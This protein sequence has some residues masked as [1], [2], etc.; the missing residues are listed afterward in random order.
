MTIS[1]EERLAGV[2]RTLN[3]SPNLR[4]AIHRAAE[5]NTLADLVGPNLRAELAR[6][7]A[8]E[9]IANGNALES[10]LPPLALEAIVKRIGRP[11]LLVANRE[12][13]LVPLD[14]FPAT[15]PAL[16]KGTEPLVQ[17][18]GRVAFVNASM[19][20]GGTGWVVKADGSKRVVATN[21]HVAKIV[22]SR[23]ADGSAF[24]MRSPAGPRYGA[25]VDFGETLVPQPGSPEPF[26]VT[27][28]IYLADDLSPDVALLEIEG[29]GLP[30]AFELADEEA[31]A[32]ELVALIGYPAFD[33]RNDVAAQEFYFHD[34]YD[35]KRYAPG[36]V[37]QPLGTE[38]IFTHDCTSLGG[39]SG[40]PLLRLRDGK[41]VGLHFAGKFGVANSAVGVT[42]LRRVLD[43]NPP[44]T[45]FSSPATTTEATSDGTHE[46]D[47]FAGRQ[48]YD[49]AFLGGGQHL[50]PWPGLPDA[51]TAVLA[52]PTDGTAANPHELR[53]THFG[54][55]Y[56]SDRRQ[57]LMTAVNIDGAKSVRIKRSRDRWFFDKRVPLEIQLNQD[58]FGDR[59]IDRGHLVRREDPNWGDDIVAGPDGPT[60]VTAS[61]ANDDTF[62]YVNAA[63]QTSKLNQGSQLWQ[64][65]ENYLLDSARTKG[66][67]LSVFTGPVFRPD[68]PD[69]HEDGRSPLLVPR[70]FW[71]V[72]V[73]VATDDTGTERLHATAYLLSQGDLIRDLLER[74]SRNEAVEGFTLGEYRTFQIAVRDLADATGYDLSAYAAVD[75]LGAS[76]D[77]EGVAEGDPVFVPLED[78]QQVVT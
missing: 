71:K 46:A 63:L 60:S 14:D 72:A 58:D 45:P 51:V 44:V 49:P 77:T 23:A 31:D 73:M 39:N 22:A 64:G 66:F 75:P 61:L 33:S 5:D 34:L 8:L 10:T 69:L 59:E 68:D 32:E 30:S 24:F 4:A 19:A 2:T 29:D 13:Q 36:K 7:P 17:S 6:T 9:A 28:V 43:G 20:W 26:K 1:D 54:V 65:L 35:V 67:R 53:Y 27:R 25:M 18:V 15:T 40:S 78:L 12:I 50:A 41:V 11:P 16:I 70:E 47:F 48:G 52:T 74:R 62:H 76:A 3:R 38:T 55:K 57:P 42:T 21:R 37:L 56:R